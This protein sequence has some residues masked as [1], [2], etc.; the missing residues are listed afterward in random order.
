ME[1]LKTSSTNWTCLHLSIMQKKVSPNYFIKFCTKIIKSFVK[2]VK[3]CSANSDC[4]SLVRVEYSF[5]ESVPLCF[6]KINYFSLF[7]KKDQYFSTICRVI[8]SLEQGHCETIFL[9]YELELFCAIWFMKEGTERTSFSIWTMLLSH[10]L[11]D[12]NYHDYIWLTK[13]EA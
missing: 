12:K 2:T 3:D 5:N 13:C 10:P 6:R 9:V 11:Q 4:A 7:F 8:W 1:Y